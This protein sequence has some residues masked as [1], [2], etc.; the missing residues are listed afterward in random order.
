MTV[1]DSYDFKQPPGTN[2]HEEPCL[3]SIYY[4]EDH[5]PPAVVDLAGHGFSIA[6]LAARNRGKL[7]GQPLAAGLPSWDDAMQAAW[8]A[9]R[10]RLEP[11][12]LRPMWWG[13]DHL[14]HPILG[15]IPARFQGQ[16][17][18]SSYNVAPAQSFSAKL[19]IP[20]PWDQWGGGTYELPGTGLLRCQTCMKA[21]RPDVL[22]RVLH[23]RHDARWQGCGLQTDAER[24]RDVEPVLAL[25]TSTLPEGYEGMV[26]SLPVAPT[27][28]E[29]IASATPAPAEGVPAQVGGITIGYGTGG[30][31]PSA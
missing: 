21:G 17:H 29:Q 10:P 20:W 23:V 6:P 11:G 13:E 4:C 7:K 9:H 28:G 25:P 3:C 19:I 5:P 14:W 15:A 2:S 18:V 31:P 22:V 27:A 8:L 1:F 16:H 24:Q 30:G 12:A 26:G